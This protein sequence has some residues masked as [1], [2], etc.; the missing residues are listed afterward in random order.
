MDPEAGQTKPL[1]P[2]AE[3]PYRLPRQVERR[4][5]QD[6]W[7]SRGHGGTGAVRSR[8]WVFW[9]LLLVYKCR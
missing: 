8:R 9:G 1:L 6:R 4:T 5:E 7:E 2:R 3:E